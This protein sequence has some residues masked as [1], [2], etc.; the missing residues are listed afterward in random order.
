M[1]HGVRLGPDGVLPHVCLSLEVTAASTIRGLLMVNSGLARRSRRIKT[2]LLEHTRRYPDWTLQDLYKLMHQSAMGN[3]HAVTDDARV[4][5]WLET[6]LEQ[7][8]PGPEEPLVDPISPDGKVLRIHL[9]SFRMQKLNPEELL[10]A[11]VLTAQVFTPS[12]RLL[13]DYMNS[14]EELARHELLPFDAHELGDYL[15][16]MRENGFP[17][18]HH[19]QGYRRKYLPA[20]RVV[21][22][23]V[24]EHTGVV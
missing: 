15:Q 16:G 21:A 23:T 22:R 3:E 14:A 18:V 24:W 19:S 4:R 7:L 12:P 11:F 17:A 8:A 2:V 9:R 13:V 1:F 20:Y 6:E 10:Q 5:E